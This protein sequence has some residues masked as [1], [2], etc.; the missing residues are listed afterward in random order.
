MMTTILVVLY[1]LG[2]ILSLIKDVD[3]FRFKYNRRFNPET[4][5]YTPYAY[6][7]YISYSPNKGW[8]Q[9]SS[10]VKYVPDVR[11][12]RT[13]MFYRGPY[14]SYINTYYSMASSDTYK[15]RFVP[16]DA[17][18]CTN[19][20]ANNRGDV[21]GIFSCPNAW[22]PRNFTYCC[23]QDYAEFCCDQ[24]PSTSRY[25][26]ELLVYAL[27]NVQLMAKWI[28]AVAAVAAIIAAI[29]I[30]VIIVIC[31]VKKRKDKP[32]DRQIFG[33]HMPVME[34]RETSAKS[35]QPMAATPAKD[36]APFS[37]STVQ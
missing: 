10:Y 22:E 20:D 12:A 7:N 34:H 2:G 21:M 31:C 13:Y 33:G 4:L 23:G 37:Y 26:S 15:N 6:S 27:T 29:I 16:S 19:Y 18:V 1:L 36:I 17:L 9:T 5:R 30:I 24:K 35:Q 8:E 25:G 11:Y 32:E 14:T 3:G 28:T